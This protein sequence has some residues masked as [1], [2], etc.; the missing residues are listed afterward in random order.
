M[1]TFCEPSTLLSDKDTEMSLESTDL[2]KLPV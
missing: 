1:H 2:K